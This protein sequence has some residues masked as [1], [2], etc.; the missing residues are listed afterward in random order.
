MK[1]YCATYIL[2]SDMKGNLM[3]WFE[4]EQEKR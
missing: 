4:F 2:N 1:V 3:D